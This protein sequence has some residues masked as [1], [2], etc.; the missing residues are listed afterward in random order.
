MAGE[1]GVLAIL[2]QS[3]PEARFVECGYRV[4]TGDN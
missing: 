4:G 3:R 1:S 2:R